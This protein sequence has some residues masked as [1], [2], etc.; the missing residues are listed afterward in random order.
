M[1]LART[2][3]EWAILVGEYN[4]CKKKLE[5][6]REALKIMKKEWHSAQRENEIY[7]NKLNQ[8]QNELDQHKQNEKL[9]TQERNHKNTTPRKSPSSPDLVSSHTSKETLAQ[10]VYEYKLANKALKH[11]FGELKRLYIQSQEDV[12]FI[13]NRMRRQSSSGSHG[14]ETNVID[15]KET[16]IRQLEE[17]KEQVAKLELDLKSIK[18]E[19]SDILSEKEHYKEKY[20]RLNMQL[21]YILGADDK[22]LFDIDALVLDNGYLK[23]KLA[24]LE[25]ERNLEKETIKKYEE[26]FEKKKNKVLHQGIESRSF[27]NHKSSNSDHSMRTVEDLRNV[28]NILS[29]TVTEKNL[30]LSHQKN[31]NKILGKRVS[32]LEKKLK[33]LE[34]AGL[35]SLPGHRGYGSQILSNNNMLCDDVKHCPGNGMSPQLGGTSE[36][37]D[38]AN[39]SNMVLLK[40]HDDDDVDGKLSSH[41]E[42]PNVLLDKSFTS[43]DAGAALLLSSQRLT[44]SKNIRQNCHVFTRHHPCWKIYLLVMKESTDCVMVI[45]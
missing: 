13:R 3:R 41:L 45:V 24:L 23:E 11:D 30:A 38:R 18:D 31:A 40:L 25:D 43:P 44:G 12:Q 20:E 2:Q 15:G 21:N 33:T 29:Q 9:L 34:V 36:I 6:K 10:L 16:C 19:N 27:H 17:Y 26:A 35:W 8:L 32:E 4:I 37:F 39:D 22:R 28:A 14:D 5:S 1:A 42:S 7:K